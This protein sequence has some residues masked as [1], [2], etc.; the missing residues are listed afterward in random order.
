MKKIFLLFV[1]AALMMN[2]SGCAA[3]LAVGALEAAGHMGAFDALSA[4]SRPTDQ[5]N[6]AI[7][8]PIT[9]YHVGKYEIRVSD[10]YFK[11]NPCIHF[12]AY[13]NG[14]LASG[15]YFEKSNPEDMAMINEFD[16]MNEIKKKEQIREWFIKY[17]TAKLDL[18]PIEE[19]K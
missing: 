4:S 2:L 6:S 13:D 19:D 18:N 8:T 9:S 16:Q 10:G 7:G 1:S 12:M 3:Q 14:K 17:T 15:I 5:P 11:K